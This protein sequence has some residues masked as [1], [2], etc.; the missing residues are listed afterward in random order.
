MKPWALLLLCAAPA[1]GHEFWIEASSFRP[2]PGEALDCRL[3]V[4]DGFPGEAYA[5][6]PRHIDSF[7]LVAG[8]RRLPVHGRDGADPAGRLHAPATG[9]TAVLVYRSTRS[10]VELPAEKFERYLVE[11]GLEAIVRQ[12][13]ERGESG[14]PG[15]ELYS[16]CAK[17]LV[18]IRGGRGGGHDVPVGL[19]LELVPE[20]D[21][22]GIEP[23][24]PLTFRVL[25]AGAPLARALVR[26][27]PKEGGGAPLTER[28]DAEGRARFRLPHAGVWMV[29][30]VAMKRA[31]EG[32]D[33]EWESLW[34]SLTFALG[35]VP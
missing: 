27:F 16:R 31:P 14:T 3:F 2:A 20:D 8:G 22:A 32:L 30:V 25:D 6:N 17:A 23:G 9:G 15:R 35:R 26:A 11:E 33:A 19:P 24:A 18:R 29:S 13:E 1:L 28:T 12:R 7:F 5:R 4:G 10:R 34:S 21:P